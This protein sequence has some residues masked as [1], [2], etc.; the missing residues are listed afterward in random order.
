MVGTERLKE[1]S[2]MS[3]LT[4]LQIMWRSYSSQYDV[5]RASPQVSRETAAFREAAVSVKTVDDLIKNRE[6]FNYVLKAYGMEDLPYP[7]MIKKI[8]TDEDFSKGFVDSRYREFMEAMGFQ[9]GGSGKFSDPA[10]IDEVVSRYQTVTFEERKGE[11]DAN[12]RLA[13]Y[14]ERVA[15]TVEN[16]YDVLADKALSE[17]VFTS[18]G[19]D[20]QVRLGDIDKLA[21]MLERRM[22]IEDFKNPDKVKSLVQRFA[23]FSDMET[24]VSTNP[25]LQLYQASAGTGPRTIINIDSSLLAEANRLKFL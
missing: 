14:F 22:S 3:T 7:A 17:V 15:P 24:Q 12:L 1:E 11:E 10:W 23:I 20:D 2:L 4:N 19:I 6:V 16:W 21:E 8:L 13:M 18:L 9:K 5:H 25:V